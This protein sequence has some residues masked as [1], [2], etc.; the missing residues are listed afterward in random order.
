MEPYGTRFLEQMDLGFLFALSLCF[1]VRTKF[2]WALLFSREKQ[3]LTNDV[4]LNRLPIGG[5]YL[6]GRSR[7]PPVFQCCSLLVSVVGFCNLL[8]ARNKNYWGAHA[9]GIP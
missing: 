7:D 2:L 3:S 5:I 1:T 6:S 4:L 9:N 8:K